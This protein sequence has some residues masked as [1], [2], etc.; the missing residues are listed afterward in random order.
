MPTYAKLTLVILA[1]GSG[2]FA[3][4]I[5]NWFKSSEPIL[6]DQYCL[7]SKVECQQGDLSVQANKDI[8]HPL[9]PTELEVN[10]PGS[11][12][13]NLVMTLQGYEMEMGTVVFK[14]NKTQ[15]GQFSGQVILP[16][17]TTDA[18]TWYGTIS[19][20]NRTFKTSIRMER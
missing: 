17:C 16:V 11:D 18:M 4:D 7:I 10:W 20:G 2:F 15:K 3:G 14:L 13:Q 1:L 9:M 8:S 19:D 12:A 5:V 6:L